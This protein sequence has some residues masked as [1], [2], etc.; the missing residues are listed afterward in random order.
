MEKQ[1]ARGCQQLIKQDKESI[2]IAPLST[3]HTVEL[4]NED[5]PLSESI[6]FAILEQSELA[7]S[8]F[9]NATAAINEMLMV[10]A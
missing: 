2:L 6:N 10:T 7:P 9:Q 8:V 1:I 3:I 4:L 5:A